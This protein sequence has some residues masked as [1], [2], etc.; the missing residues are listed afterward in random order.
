MITYRRGKK[1]VR[2]GKMKPVHLF[3]YSRELDTYS[4]HCRKCAREL[5]REVNKEENMKD[6]P[7]VT[8]A[9]ELIEIYHKGHDGKMPTLEEMIKAYDILRPIIGLPDNMPDIFKE[10]LA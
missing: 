8:F 6:A 3:F 7:G 9:K 10:L 4:A 2:C 1:C 5:L